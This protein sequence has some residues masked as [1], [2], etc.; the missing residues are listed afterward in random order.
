MKSKSTN[1]FFNFSDR[2]DLV[3][4]LKPELSISF[5]ELFEQ[6][7]QIAF[8]LSHKGIKKDN[9]IPLLIDDNLLF[10]KTVI[11]LW[12]LGAIPVP[13]NTRLLD[14]EI[15]STLDDFDFKFLVT[16]KK[17]SFNLSKNELGIIDFNKITSE[18]DETQSFS[19]PIWEKEAVVIF[20]SGSTGRPKG[21]VHTFSSLINSIENSNLVL[22]QRENDSW[23]ASL[24]FYHIG[25]FQ[26]ICRSLFYGCS[27]ILPQ[28]LQTDDLTKSIKEFNPTHLS[29]VSTQLEKLIQQSIKPNDSLRISLIGG[30]FV[31][32]EL[33]IEADMLGWKTFRVYGSSETASMVTAIS[34]NEIKERP[35]SVGK[36]LN[37]V[38]INIAEDSEILVKSDSLFLKYLSDESETKLKLVDDYYYTGD[39]GFLDDDGYL[40]IEAR[41]TDLIV[42]GGENV[43]PIE[44]EKA[45]LKINGIKEVCVFPK[46][47]KTWGQIVVC[48]IVKEDESIN[49][50]IVKEN[51]KKIIAGYKIPKEF[52]FTCELPKTGLGKLEREK[53]RK[54]F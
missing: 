47:S 7:N 42:T 2:K 34:V 46:P 37:N 49:G 10:I 11:A 15:K 24:P 25:G 26:I 14:D 31:D 29:L 54:M 8:L 39:L 16:D 35:Q 52:I 6:S 33:M 9:Y 17:S 53:I 32:D 18:N 43:N 50:I 28:S 51:L 38:Q 5:K 41:R 48:V 30:G 4:V 13:L 3:A 21:V 19:I 22:N 40:F 20:T 36:A 45:I 23:L 12:F 1:N 27:I 44:V